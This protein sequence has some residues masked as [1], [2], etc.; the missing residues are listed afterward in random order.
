MGDNPSQGHKHGM[1]MK[2]TITIFAIIMTIVS[3]CLVA[4][5]FFNLMNY[6][7]LIRVTRDYVSWE[8]KVKEMVSS[9]DYLTEQVRLFVE[10]GDRK[11]MDNYFTESDQTRRREDALEFIAERFPLSDAYT[12]LDNAMNES[13]KL[14]F[15]EYKAMRLKAESMGDDLS[16]YDRRVTSVLLSE[17][18][19]ALSNAEKAALART[20]L[21]DQKY[22]SSKEKIINQ[23]DD[24]LKNLVGKLEE[25]QA[26]AEFRLRFAMI[27]ELVLI[28]SYIFLSIFIVILT[29]RRVFTPLI[30]SIPF[31]ENDSPLPVQGAYE[32]RML[33]YAYNLMYESN[34]RSKNRLKFKAEHDALTGALNRNAFEKVLTSSEEG[35]VAFLILDVDNFKQINDNHGHLAGDK[36]L[37]RVVELMRENFRTEDSIF[38]IGGDEFAVVLFGIDENSLKIIQNKYD[39]I[40][41]SLTEDAKAGA[42]EITL[43]AGVA[44]GERID[45]SLME[46]AD[47][48]LYESKAAGKA[49]C[50]FFKEKI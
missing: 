46:R 23:T 24:C 10:T 42:P 48:A 41:E 47:T 8:E 43:S 27:Y 35:N 18:E 25:E 1:P 50:S 19:R 21:F 14:M 11:H 49:C 26:D 13:R 37:T 17:E 36:V 29:S 39:R 15:T 4:G 20:I 45:T 31:I 3:A 7:D 22:S 28:A 30:H 38:R 40:N 34:R 44:F 9:S 5:L 33:A 16:T 6:N 12:S 32:L 2:R